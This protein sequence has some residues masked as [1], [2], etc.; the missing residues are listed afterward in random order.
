MAFCCD[1]CAIAHNI[2]ATN[3]TKPVTYSSLAKFLLLRRERISFTKSLTMNPQANPVSPIVDIDLSHPHSL[4]R[5]RRVQNTIN[6]PE[7]A[8]YMHKYTYYG[9]SWSNRK[10]SQLF[11]IRPTSIFDC[12]GALKIAQKAQLINRLVTCTKT[13]ALSCHYFFSRIGVVWLI[14]EALVIQLI[15]V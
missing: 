10:F 1:R 15:S 6:T 5:A 7:N 12:N 4:K 11:S 3:K 13:S 2:T 9:S 8:P 14:R